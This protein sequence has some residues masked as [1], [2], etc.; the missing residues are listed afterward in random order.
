MQGRE[1]KGDKPRPITFTTTQEKVVR[2]M[3]PL[4]VLGT[5]SHGSHST[6]VVWLELE[7]G[8]CLLSMVLIQDPLSSQ[9][10]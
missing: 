8:V 1:G 5:R 7:L 10:G 6:R 4:A 3:L 2:E 9:Q